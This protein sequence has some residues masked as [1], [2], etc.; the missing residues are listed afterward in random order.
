M[1][2]LNNNQN[3]NTEFWVVFGRKLKIT[4]S[5]LA[6]FTF[7]LFIATIG[8][9]IDSGKQVNITK[10]TL[11]ADKRAFVFANGITS[12]WEKDQKT[13]LYNWRFRPD[14]HNSGDS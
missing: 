2:A 9:W 4:D 3:E 8:L 7:C 12:F 13:G 14:L 11:V 5:L 1:T 6:L 10:D